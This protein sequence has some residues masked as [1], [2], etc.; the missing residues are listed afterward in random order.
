MRQR[1]ER[2]DGQLCRPEPQTDTW[3]VDTLD[4]LIHCSVADRGN[5]ML[6]DLALRTEACAEYWL[7]SPK[8][9]RNSK[10]LAAASVFLAEAVDSTAQGGR[11]RW[12]AAPVPGYC[13]PAFILVGHQYIGIPPRGQVDVR[14]LP[15]WAQDAR[16][17]QD[18]CS[19]QAGLDSTATMGP[20]E[21]QT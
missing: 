4:Q 3:R 1:P 11:R 2:D 6:T 7:T 13:T 19:G 20:P 21:A 18:K 17:Q 10:D 15:E 9:G 14:N 8:Q 12:P 16:T 5:G